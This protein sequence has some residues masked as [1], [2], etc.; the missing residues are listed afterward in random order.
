[1]AVR[2]SSPGRRFLLVGLA[3]FA[4][5][6]IPVSVSAQTSSSTLARVIPQSLRVRAFGDGVIAGFG[7]ASSGALVP[8]TNATDCR[9][10][11]IGDGSATSAGTR[12]SSNGRN[13]PGSPPDDVS[14]SAD[15]GRT[16][17]ASWAAQVSQTLGA[18]DFANYAVTGSSLA[19]WLNLP[20]D[21]AAP[22]EGAQHNLLERI[23]Q[24]DHDIVLASL[25]GEALLEQPAGA[26]RSCARWSDQ[27]A[28][29]PQFV[30]C[31][32]RLLAAQLVKQR[33]MAIS[34]DLLAHTIN[35][36]LLYSHYSPASPRLSALLPWQQ[37]VLADAINAQIDA[38]VVGVRESG[39]SWAERI[40]VVESSSFAFGCLWKTVAGPSLFGPNWWTSGPCMG[41]GKLS[42]PISLGTIPGP[43]AQSAIAA[44]AV[45]V[46]RNRN[47]N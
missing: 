26:V 23:E 1:M 46:I 31:V 37:V 4:L 19:S 45:S 39:A 43:A 25:G 2:L 21:D 27:P 24:D 11:W 17:G 20:H 41:D 16:N 10:L 18:V 29:R 42:T 44:A 13:G 9:P 35:A 5:A 22:A 3:S 28:Q 40:D 32:N 30:E 7:V 14:F 36:K 47:W 6:L 15:F 38:A 12:C 8:I 34:F 33:L